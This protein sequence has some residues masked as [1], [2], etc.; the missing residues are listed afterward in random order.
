MKVLSRLALAAAALCI[1]GTSAGA[2][3]IVLMTTGAVQ[4]ILHGLIPSFEASSGN[5][6]T[7]TVLGTGGAVDAIKGGKFA[8]LILLGPDALNDLAAAGKVDA[9]TI[10]PAFN[11]RIGLAVRAGAKAPDISTPDALKKT[12]LDAK[13]IG[14]S[15][16]PSGEHFS[17]VIIFKLGIADALRPKMTNV[18]GRP[19][20]AAV[21]TGEIEVGIHQIAELMQIPGVD[22]VGDLPAEL[23]K[24]IV[25]A[26]ALTPMAKQPEATKAFVN[27]LS[28]P[29]S[30]P[31][32]RKNGMESAL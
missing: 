22:I 2:A 20:A 30:A 31:V 25:Y 28:S 13:S 3:E 19:V 24:K 29:S 5:K 9:A 32:V 6:V 12:L 7:M 15:I 14:Y 17:K 21:A 23:N 8:D 18:R 10:K 4:A 16:G 26:T 11:S 1:F 27:Y